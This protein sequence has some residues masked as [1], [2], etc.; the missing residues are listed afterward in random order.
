MLLG[1]SASRDAR[2]TADD[3]H[4]FKKNSRKHGNTITSLRP[5]TVKPMEQPDNKTELLTYIV[6]YFRY[7]DELSL[8]KGI[9]R[10]EQI[11]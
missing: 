3:H 2:G 6:V 10:C 1:D 7:R 5:A 9:S 11:L 4:E 8:Q